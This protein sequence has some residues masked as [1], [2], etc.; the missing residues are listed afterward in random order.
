MCLLPPPSMVI[1][2]V[3]F[4]I[5]SEEKINPGH[6]SDCQEQASTL[7]NSVHT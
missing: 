7:L 1:S 6:L 2:K 5:V 4:Q 3:M